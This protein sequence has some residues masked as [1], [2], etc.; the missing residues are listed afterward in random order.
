MD[1]PMAL[2]FSPLP[3]S[4]LHPSSYS[5]RGE[6]RLSLASHWQH[7]KITSPIRVATLMKV[8]LAEQRLPKSSRGD[9]HVVV[10]QE[11]AN[12]SVKKFILMDEAVGKVRTPTNELSIPDA[13]LESTW[14]HRLWVGAG[15]IAIGCMF[16][17][18]VEVADSPV[19]VASAI[20]AAI[21]GYVL[22]DLG[23]GIYHWGIDNYGDANTPIFGSQI[24]AFQ[25]H[26]K[27]PWTIT[28]RQFSNN[29]H[30]L[31]RPAFFALLP[32]ILLSS[33]SALDAFLGV[34]LASVVFSQQFH[35]WAHAKKTEL[36][37]V[38]LRLQEMGLLLPQKMHGAHH[39]PPYHINY[40]IVSGIW[41][42]V[43]NQTGFFTKL[44]SAI[45]LRWGMKPRTWSDTTPEWMQEGSYF[46]DGTHSDSE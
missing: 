6:L 19:A 43:L 4:P 21:V 44:E 18:V 46:A 16:Y 32:F 42:P 38:V 1:L 41:N 39:R 13:S 30:A 8:V 28:K 20:V 24:S 29:I 22:A 7:A 17:K 25:G 31:A 15:S 23:T 9:D 37:A 5:S 12:A 14:V 26:H 10:F 27:K 34:F 40:C 35:S 2:R 3:C 33:N 36:P 45:Y 11:M